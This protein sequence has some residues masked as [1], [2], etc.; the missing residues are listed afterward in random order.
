MYICTLGGYIVRKKY[1]KKYNST[2]EKY[3]KIVVEFGG[4][5]LGCFF[6]ASG[7]PK[8]SPKNSRTVKC[9]KCIFACTLYL[10]IDMR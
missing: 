7:S 4:I 1:P 5:F 10:V 8:K 2:N 6:S 3:K 9:T